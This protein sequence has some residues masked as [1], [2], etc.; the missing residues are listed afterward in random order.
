MAAKQARLRRVCERKPSGKLKCPE[1]L[2]E[3]WK[4]PANRDSMLEKLEA[5]DWKK[6]AG[7]AC[8]EEIN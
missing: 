5:A 7:V 1:W 2:H 3:Q 8:L 6:A 4:N